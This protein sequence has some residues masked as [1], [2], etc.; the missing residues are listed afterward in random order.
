MSESIQKDLKNINMNMPLNFN[1]LK[2][3][4]NTIKDKNEVIIKHYLERIIY[5]SK[6]S[7]E[8]NIQLKKVFEDSR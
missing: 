2:D 4:I 3:N 6:L 5:T 1:S 7:N 8:T